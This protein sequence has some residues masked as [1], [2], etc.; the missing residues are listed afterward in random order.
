MEHLNVKYTEIILARSKR[1]QPT[2]YLEALNGLC[3]NEEKQKC[4]LLLRI[5]HIIKNL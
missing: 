4:F 5:S 1:Y 2:D 3:Q